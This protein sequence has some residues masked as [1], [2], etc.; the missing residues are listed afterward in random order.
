MKKTTKR[1]TMVVAI[2][3]S[4]VLLT[5]SVV[6]TTLAKFVI[7]K[8]ATTEVTLNKFG[9]EVT[10]SGTGSATTKKGDSIIYTNTLTMK[11]GDSKSITAKIKGKP[12]V[13][14]NVTIDVNVEYDTTEF[15]VKGATDFTAVKTDTV[16]FPIGFKV[17]ST[18][19]VT[20]YSSSDGAAISNAIEDKIEGVLTG[21]TWT[22][23]D[24]LTTTWGTGTG[25][26]DYTSSEKNISLNF[27]WPKNHNGTDTSAIYDE[28]GTYLTKDGA[29]SFKVTY[30]ITIE[31]Q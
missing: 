14:S 29:K 27:Y 4:L 25:V 3:L 30:I 21:F 1:L 13:A 10:F 28:I 11:P 24:T 26:P 2:L 15:T 5:S 8:E 16:Y 20:P 17:G 19:V 9:V 22:D 12:T 18:S 31:Q 7:R 23:G 6:S